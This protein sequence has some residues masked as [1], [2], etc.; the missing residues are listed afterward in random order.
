MVTDAALQSST[1]FTASDHAPCSFYAV[2]AYEMTSI[3]Y[4]ILFSPPP[5][6]DTICRAK[7]S[8][9]LHEDLIERYMSSCKCVDSP[10][11]RLTLEW[12]KIYSAR[13]KLLLFHWDRVFLREVAQ[14]K[15]PDPNGDLFACVR[16]LEKVRELRTGAVYSRWAWLWQNCVEWVRIEKRSSW[17]PIDVL[18]HIS[19][20]CRTSLQLD[21]A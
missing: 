9:E 3:V 6:I 17:H 13:V 4:T 12:C 21:Y 20:A 18:T 1:F 16:I 11:C 15:T 5:G 2:A 10:I 14:E 7:F 19:S 8:D